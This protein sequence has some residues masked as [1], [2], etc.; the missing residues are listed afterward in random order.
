MNRI[1]V[2]KETTDEG[3]LVARNEKGRLSQETGCGGRF[4]GPF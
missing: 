4:T 2:Q 1:R 3:R